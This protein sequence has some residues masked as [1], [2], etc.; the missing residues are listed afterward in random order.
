GPST[1]I[2]QLGKRYVIATLGSV[3]YIY[4]YN[5]ETSELDQLSFYFAPFFITSVNVLKNFVIIGD[6]VQGLQFLQ[7]NEENSE[8]SLLGKDYETVLSL[9]SSFVLDG[10]KL[11]MVTADF[12]GNIQLL[13]Y[14]PRVVESRKGFK[15]LCMADFYLGSTVSMFLP[16]RLLNR[17]LPGREMIP[18]FKTSVFTGTIYGEFGIVVPIDE[19]MYRRLML[20]QQIMGSVMKT[21]CALNPRE[22]RFI[23]T[24]EMKLERKRGLV[25]GSLL[26]KFMDLDSRTQDELCAAMGTS[27]DVVF[28]NL[29]EIDFSWGFF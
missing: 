2:K 9:N 19:G 27:V 3:L 26:W 4:N 23:K 28:E 14:N 11:G 8:L 29:L 22:Y 20:L 13:Q 15:L 12:E 24:S 7:W 17:A 16:H 18:S 21:T 5:M 1:I 10:N 6:S 25:D